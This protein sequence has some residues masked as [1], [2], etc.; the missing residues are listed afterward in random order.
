[1]SRVRAISRLSLLSWIL[2]RAR[3]KFSQKLISCRA[4]PEAGSLSNFVTCEYITKIYYLLILFTQKKSYAQIYKPNYVFFDGQIS[5]EH[6]SCYISHI[7]IN[8]LCECIFMICSI[9]SLKFQVH[10]AQSKYRIKETDDKVNE[11]QES[12]N[13]AFELI[14]RHFYNL[15]QYQTQRLHCRN[16]S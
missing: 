7:N 11:E 4:V 3:S 15:M 12:I 9:N 1:M 13:T 2:M 5:L 6:L 10:K 8:P 14:R 16:C